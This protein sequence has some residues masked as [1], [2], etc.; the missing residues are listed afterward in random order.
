M[1][2][3][4]HLFIT[5]QLSE[6][7][8][9]RVSL[10]ATTMQAKGIDSMLISSNVHLY[11]FSGRIYAG[12]ALIQS[13]GEITYYVRRPI[14]FENEPNVTYIRK[15]EQIAELSSSQPKTIALELDTMT[16]NEILRLQKVFPN[17]E[18]VN[19][20][21]ILR[22]QRSV[23]SDYEISL[24]KQCSGRHVAAYS[25]IPRMY[26]VGMSD[27]ELQICIENK[28]RLEGCLGIFRIAGQS[29]E[30][31]MG[32]ILAG[33]NAD[34][35]SPYDF[36][37]GGHGLDN[38]LPIGANG[39]IPTHGQT[40]MVDMCGNFNGY[41]TD[42]TRCYSIGTISELAMLAHNTSIQ[43]CHTLA[44]EAHAGTPAKQLYERALQIATEAGLADYFMGHNQKAGFV[45]HG[46]GIEVNEAPVLAPR[47]KEILQCGN[48]IA[49]EPKFIIP[50]I[51]A[52]GI[53]NTYVVRE[54]NL[55]CIT[56]MPEEIIDLM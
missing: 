35:A 49:I 11:Y 38:A 6:E 40:I 56:N 10:V 25:H 32:N 17:A 51:G 48:V 15:P 37:V 8:K 43:I 36:A 4:S 28:L 55:E 14:G 19:A 13:N 52:V 5:P 50:G 42:M 30:I 39:T 18:M 47:S 45:G 21:P 1:T 16:Y 23:K 44:K 34:N 24:L 7:L 2:Q 33:N 20:S 12:Y 22:E 46:V 53:E 3:T 41:M 54:N 27:I 31:F 26:K 29:M 9:N